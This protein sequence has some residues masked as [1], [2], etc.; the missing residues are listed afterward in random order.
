MRA[1]IDHGTRYLALRIWSLTQ[2][3]RTPSGYY[4][5]VSF[6]ELGRP[7]Q[8]CRCMDLRAKGLLSLS[9]ASDGKPGVL[10]KPWV[11]SMSMA[12]LQQ[13]LKEL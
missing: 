13:H 8:D 7:F 4:T 10:L 11:V 1:M 12:E 9:T 2:K 5:A 6:E 3:R